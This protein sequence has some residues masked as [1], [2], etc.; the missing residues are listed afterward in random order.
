M[1]ALHALEWQRGLSILSGTDSDA[2]LAGDR[3]ETVL[4]TTLRLDDLLGL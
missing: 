4:N 1:P 3:R 2:G